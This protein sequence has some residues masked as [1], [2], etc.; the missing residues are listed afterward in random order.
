[1]NWIKI[2]G[3]VGLLSLIFGVNIILWQP[4]VLKTIPP[5]QAHVLTHGVRGTGDA[6]FMALG[7][8]DSP[9][10]RTVAFTLIA[11]GSLLVVGAGVIGCSQK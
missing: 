7:L 1:M 9:S 11:L 2:T 10:W 4:S 8:F 6:A 3:A 5:D